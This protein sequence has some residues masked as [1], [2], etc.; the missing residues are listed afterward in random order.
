M[1]DRHPGKMGLI[2]NAGKR[3]SQRSPVAHLLNPSDSA[4]RIPA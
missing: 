3:W 4:S 2:A 1:K